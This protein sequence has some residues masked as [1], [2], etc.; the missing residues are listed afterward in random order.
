MNSYFVH[1]FF[2]SGEHDASSVAANLQQ[3]DLQKDDRGAP[4]ED[5][6][7][8]PV[9]IPNHLQLHTPDCL[10]LSFGSFR[11]GPEPDLASSH[12]LKSDLEETSPAVDVSAVGHSDARYVHHIV[13]AVF[14]HVG[15]LTSSEEICYPAEILN[16]METSIS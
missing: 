1:H 3:L 13:L 8:P 6:N 9:V 2:V 4:P 16:T 5:E 15:C 10:H 11:S 7:P 12:P 14:I